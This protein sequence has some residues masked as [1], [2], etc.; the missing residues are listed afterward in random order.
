MIVILKMVENFITSQAG[1]AETMAGKVCGYAEGAANH[2][3]GKKDMVLGAVRGIAT[4]R[5][6]G[7]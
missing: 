6:L 1:E 4:N 3:S 5:Q 2:I 7:T